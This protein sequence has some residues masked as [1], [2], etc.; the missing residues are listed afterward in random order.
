MTTPLRI[1]AEVVREK[2]RS[3]KALLVCAYE[4]E[5]KFTSTHLEGALGWQAFQS[6]LPE[7]SKAQESIF[8][9]A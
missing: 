6:K 7:L 4:E 8:Y 3:G 5:D 1:S 2:T 9:C